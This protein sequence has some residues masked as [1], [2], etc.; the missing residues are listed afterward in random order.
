MSVQQISNITKAINRLDAAVE[1]ATSSLGAVLHGN[2][3]VTDR[4]LSYKEVVR[5]QRIL[6]EMFS[7][8]TLCGEAHDA[9]LLIRLVHDASIMIK[10][11]AHHLLSSLR[12]LKAMQ[13]SVSF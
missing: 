7:K 10:L 6:V 3:A 11:D 8:A 12:E 1:S 4:M 13:S 5:R 2:Q 9:T